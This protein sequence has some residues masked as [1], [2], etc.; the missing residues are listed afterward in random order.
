MYELLNK[1]MTMQTAESITPMQ[2]KK[3][4]ALKNRLGWTDEQ[5]R[6]YLMTEGDGFALSCKDL[7]EDEAEK[8]IRKME[9]AAAA[10][11]VWKRFGSGGVKKYDEL[12][13]RPGMASPKQLRMIEAMWAEASKYKRNTE[14]RERALRYFLHRIAGVDRLEFLEQGQVQKIIKAIFKMKERRNDET[15]RCKTLR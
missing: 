11:G 3:I 8:L 2:I 5:Y 7:S 4:H 13:E 10:K 9:L 6:E 15:K 12:G 14:A 1:E